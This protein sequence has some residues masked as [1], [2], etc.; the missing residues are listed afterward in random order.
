MPPLAVVIVV[1]V[2][3]TT[4]TPSISVTVN[5]SLFGSVS[6]TSALPAADVFTWVITASSFASG[7]SLSA[8]FGSPLTVR[9]TVASSVAPLGSATL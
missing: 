7:A 8:G 3:A 1:G 9:L 4:A 5:G 6:L 2:P